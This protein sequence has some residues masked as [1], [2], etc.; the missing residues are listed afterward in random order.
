MKMQRLQPLRPQQ[1]PKEN[2]FNS[3]QLEAGARLH[4]LPNISTSIVTEGYTAKARDHRDSATVPADWM[5][6]S[7]LIGQVCKFQALIHVI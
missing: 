3:D 4:P 5:G 2:N 1:Y 6:M 7:W